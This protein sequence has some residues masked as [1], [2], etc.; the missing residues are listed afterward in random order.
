MYSNDNLV[1]LYLYN[2][3]ENWEWPY[4]DLYDL[5]ISEFDSNDN[6]VS[7]KISK[8][9]FAAKLETEILRF[10]PLDTIATDDKND[11]IKSALRKELIKNKSDWWTEI[12]ILEKVI[13]KNRYKKR[14]I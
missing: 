1:K 5:M 7:V 10:Y 4:R 12:Y 14:M 8:N 9:E 11:K 3:I 2:E 13:Q 6:H